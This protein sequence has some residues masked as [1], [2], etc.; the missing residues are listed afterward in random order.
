M[1]LCF[2]RRETCRA[3]AEGKPIVIGKLGNLVI[4]DSLSVFE[5]DLEALSTLHKHIP[6]DLNSVAHKHVAGFQD[7]S[8]IELDG[9]E[10]IE[11]LENKSSS[12]EVGTKQVRR[13]IEIQF[14][15]P[16]LLSNPLQVFLVLPQEGI[17]NFLI[18][19]Q[20]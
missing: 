2:P 5:H 18:G 3:I 6:G 19:E 17:W 9:R 10:S 8:T 1:I 11:A 4:T 15:H 13:R 14:V 20:I 7:L 12:V 16:C